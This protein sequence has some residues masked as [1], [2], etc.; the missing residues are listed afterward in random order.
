M[1]EIPRSFDN[2]YDYCWSVCAFEHL[3]S[4]QKGLDFV[5]NAMNVLKPGELPST[6]PNLITLMNQKL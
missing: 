4:I 3:G 1:N 6:R 5:K 2:Q